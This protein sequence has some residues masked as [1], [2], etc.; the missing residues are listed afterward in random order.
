VELDIRTD[1]VF[2]SYADNI[3]RLLSEIFKSGIHLTNTEKIQLIPQRKYNASPLQRQ[4][5]LRLFK[6]LIA[7]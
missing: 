6:F 7:I 4:T 3:H 1:I 2:I 5:M